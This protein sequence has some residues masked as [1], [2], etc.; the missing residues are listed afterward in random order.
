MAGSCGGLGCDIAEC[1]TGTAGGDDKG[2]VLRIAEFGDGFVDDWEF[3]GDDFVEGHPWGGEDF[4]EV[5]GDSGSSKILIDPQVG[6]VRHRNNTDGSR[7]LHVCY[8][9]GGRL[10]RICGLLI[11]SITIYDAGLCV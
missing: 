4:A 3:V 9:Q 1:G 10:Q 6:S 8:V 7:C 11:R 5:I 2:A